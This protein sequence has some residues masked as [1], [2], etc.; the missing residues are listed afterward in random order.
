MLSQ[1]FQFFPLELVVDK[2]FEPSV[3]GWPFTSARTRD[4]RYMT[5]AADT[6]LR[7]FYDGELGTHTLP[8]PLRGAG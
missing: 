5:G 2:L 4:G 6:V 3:T 1:P 8:A 7:G